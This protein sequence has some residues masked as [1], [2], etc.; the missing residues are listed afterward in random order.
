[1]SSQRSQEGITAKIRP[2]E[3]QAEAWRLWFDSM[4]MFL[5]YGGAAGGGKSWFGCE[6]LLVLAF[7]YPGSRWFIGRNELKRLMQ[8]TYVTWVQVCKHHKIPD[9]DWK[10]NGQYNYIE[11]IDGKAKGTRIDLLDVAKTPSDPMYERFGSLEYTGGW[12][13][14]AG[15]V[16]F[17]AFDVLK[18]RLGRWKNKEMGFSPKMLLTFNPKKG[19]LHEM[20]YAPWKNGKLPE[21]TRFVQALFTDNPHTRENYGKMLSEIKDKSTRERLMNGNWDYESDP[22]VLITYE[23]MT[24]LWTN[25]VDKGAKSITADIARYGS[26]KTVLYLWDGLEVIKC[27]HYE[28][29]GVDETTSFLRTWARDYQVP[30]SRIV[31]D[32]DGV[33]GGVVDNLRGIKGFV[34]NS[35]PIPDKTGKASNFQNLKAQCSYLL[36]EYVNE[37]KI[38][39]KVKDLFIQEKIKEDLE[40]IKSHDADKDGKIKVLPKDKVKEV[41]GRSPDFGDAL[42][43]R[44]LLELK[45][46]SS[47]IP[48]ARFGAPGT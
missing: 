32:E 2:N 4:V 26:D 33:G 1:M 39:I 37:R 46:A 14:E 18:S 45:P 29:R 23:A 41:I 35:A 3:K 15:E 13:E 28:K 10:L 17:L 24:D 8:S 19:W 40:Q 38:A 43:M 6:L 47:D 34:A 48:L 5:G 12:L 7:R 25:T 16:D 9:T 20:F 36:A 42:V 11:F 21:N 30:F 27:E 44:M 22:S 31:V